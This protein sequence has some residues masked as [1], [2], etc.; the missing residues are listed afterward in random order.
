MYEY[1]SIAVLIII[2]FRFLNRQ[3]P[4][5]VLS[6][7]SRPGK[8]YYLKVAFLFLILQLR[9]VQTSLRKQNKSQHSKKSGY[10]IKSRATIEEMDCPQTLSDHPKAIDAVY[11]NMASP[12]G[13]HLITG[14]ATR[15]HGVVN[16]FLFIQVPGL[17]LLSTPKLPDTLMFRDE[18]YKPEEY[19]AEGIRLVPFQPMRVWRLQ[20]NGKMIL[21]NHPEETFDVRLNAVWSSALPYFDF[22]TDM[23]ALSVSKS[24]SVERWSRDYFSSLRNFH[25]THYEQ[26]G[27]MHGQLHINDRLYSFKMSGVRDHSYGEKREWKNFHRYVLH[28]ITLEDGRRISVGVVSTPVT[29]S[30]VE[31]GYIYLAD[32]SLIPV[33]YCSLQLHQHGEKGNPPTDY[34]FTV[35]AGGQLYTIQVEVTSSAEFFIGWEWET[36]IVEQFARFTVNGV[37]GWGAAEWQYRHL[38]GRPAAVSQ[39]DPVWTR[40]INKG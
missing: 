5:S 15:P 26:H 11:F 25:Q 16:G 10:G 30:R 7:Y 33:A 19:G 27:D 28:F 1:I 6:V 39:L 38:E 23:D 35:S 9:K 32:G 21:N 36:R 2:L 29:F 8:Y 37:K 31:I 40:D 13:W 34:G 17:G 22:D 18:T 14:T 20:Y 24:M 4:P 3:N 12:K